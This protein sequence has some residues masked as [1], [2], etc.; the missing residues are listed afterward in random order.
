MEPM[1]QPPLGDSED[2]IDLSFVNNVSFD[3]NVLMKN[4]MCLHALSVDTKISEEFR[5]AIIMPTISYPIYDTVVNILLDT[6]STGNF[7]STTLVQKLNLKLHSIA[8]AV[9]IS[10]IGS[11]LT[12]KT[13]KMANINL[14]NKV[15]SC[16][17][18]TCV[19]ESVPKTPLD[20]QELIGGEVELAQSFPHGELIIDIIIGLR[21]LHK[22]ITTKPIKIVLES[23]VLIPTIAGYV[24]LG[25]L[26]QKFCPK[27]QVNIKGESR[28]IALVTNEHLSRLLKKFFATEDKFLKEG[29][30]K[31]TLSKD[32]LYA[33]Q[34]FK[35]IYKIL[36]ILK[37]NFSSFH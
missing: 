34:Y 33:I 6:G 14:F 5:D 7:I 10:G 25:P 3:N 17:V 35:E 16:Y 8:D 23:M 26:S 24:T 29:V 22:L 13:S 21:S 20:L 32:H 37:K 4:E 12:Q 31:Y 36:S 30:D 11:N 1:S 27:Y 2:L 18:L 19:C 15:F 28:E 9:E